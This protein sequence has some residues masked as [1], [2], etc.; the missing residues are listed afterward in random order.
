MDR[1]EVKPPKIIENND[2]NENIDSDDTDF[3]NEMFMK[4]N[5]DTIREWKN[6]TMSMWKVYEKRIENYEK[7][8]NQCLNYIASYDELKS[9][10]KEC[11]ELQLLLYE[12]LNR[13]QILLAKN[14]EIERKLLDENIRRLQGITDER[15]DLFEIIRKHPELSYQFD[16]D[17]QNQNESHL[18]ETAV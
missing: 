9:T 17:F 10:V 1:K 14:D 5:K 12:K 11:N 13:A 3:S 4:V 15:F 16:Y 7:T 8:Q 18:R 6:R 2:N